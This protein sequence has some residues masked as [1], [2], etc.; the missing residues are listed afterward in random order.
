MTVL[1]ISITFC[2]GL[3]VIIC[4]CNHLLNLELC[5][6]SKLKHWSHTYMHQWQKPFYSKLYQL[7]GGSDSSNSLFIYPDTR[8]WT[9]WFIQN[10]HLFAS[11]Y[12]LDSYRKTCR[13]ALQLPVAIFIIASF[14]NFKWTELPGATVQTSNN[15]EK[16]A[17]LQHTAVQHLVY[18]FILC[19]KALIELMKSLSYLMILKVFASLFCRMRRQLHRFSSAGWV[20]LVGE[21]HTTSC[22]VGAVANCFPE[23]SGTPDSQT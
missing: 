2:F 19:R 3:H 23:T 12:N 8:S 13:G 10:N 4:L 7:L 18:T 22:H 20:S 9:N 14:R 21:W 15:W 1:V 11:F 17:I 16:E 6:Y 5:D